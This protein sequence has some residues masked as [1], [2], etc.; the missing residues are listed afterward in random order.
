LGATN[1]FDAG[2][3]FAQIGY[4]FGH[5]TPQGDLRGRFGYLRISEEF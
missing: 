4:S 2:L 3:P 5:D 1:L